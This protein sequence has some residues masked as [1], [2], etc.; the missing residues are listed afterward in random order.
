[1][2]DA[3]TIMTILIPAL[4]QVES[5]GDARK[6]G[7]NGKAVGVLQIHNCVIDEVNKTYAAVG[8]IPAKYGNSF[9]YDDRRFVSQSKAICQY[10]LFR[11]G[12]DY[13]RKTHKEATLEVLA[14]IWNGGPN[15]WKKKSTERYWLKV[16]KE[17]TK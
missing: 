15:A 4:I 14:R 2:F 11:W 3:N 8:L 6:I 16:E 1:M 13:E 7:D 9:L 5:G 17:L 12:Q 10:Y